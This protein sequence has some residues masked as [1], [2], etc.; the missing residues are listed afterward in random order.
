M[1]GRGL[2]PRQIMRGDKPPAYLYGDTI[3][4]MQSLIFFFGQAETV[5][6]RKSLE[7]A[8]HFKIESKYEKFNCFRTIIAIY[9]FMK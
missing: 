3:C 6:C 1:V 7:N 4:K 5:T 2:V 8:A 9:L